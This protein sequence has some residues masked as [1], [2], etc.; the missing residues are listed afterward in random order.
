MFLELLRA[1]WPFARRPTAVTTPLHC[2]Y[3]GGVWSQMDRKILL[4]GRWVKHRVWWIC[5]RCGRQ[6]WEEQET[7]VAEDKRVP[8]V[9]A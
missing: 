2:P 7:L 3:C 1:L 9:F 6:F 4:N 5:H 8:C